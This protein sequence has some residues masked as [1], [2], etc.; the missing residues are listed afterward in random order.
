MSNCTG[1]A[2]PTVELVSAEVS[3]DPDTA[4]ERPTD[5]QVSAVHVFDG[6]GSVFPHELLELWRLRLC[7]EE[8]GEETA[9]SYP[10]IDAGVRLER[11]CRQLR[12]SFS[13]GGYDEFRHARAEVLSW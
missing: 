1:A 12:P 3:R 4:L 9:Q 13:R 8:K 7:G 10:F 2:T 6:G 5:A 11:E